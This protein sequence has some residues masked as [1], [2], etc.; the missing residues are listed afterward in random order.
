MPWAKLAV[1]YEVWV[2]T[3]RLPWDRE[4]SQEASIIHVD[5]TRMYKFT[6]YTKNY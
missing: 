5:I 4:G 3:E 1:L 2:R 6:S